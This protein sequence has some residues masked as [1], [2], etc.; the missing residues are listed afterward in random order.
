[1][2]TQFKITLSKCTIQIIIILTSLFF[3][4]GRKPRNIFS[5]DSEKSTPSIN[6]LSLP[7]IKEIKL[8]R[9]NN[10]NIISWQKLTTPVSVLSKPNNNNKQNTDDDI[11]KFELIGYNIYK[12]ASHAFIPQE[13]LNPT[14]TTTTQFE[15]SSAS[16]K[17]KWCYVVRGVFKVKENIIEGPA[18][19]IVCEKN[20]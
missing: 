17:Y 3:H 15:D 14:L 19:Q 18:S 2:K 11:L 4:C 9:D 6:P 7:T 1:M 8:T 20:R 16:S 13:P 5:F 12:F 10:K